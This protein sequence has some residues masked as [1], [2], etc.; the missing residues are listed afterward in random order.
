MSDASR[1][2]YASASSPIPPCV[3]KTR[4]VVK[5]RF[6][7]V[8]NSSIIGTF[9][10]TFMLFICWSNR[11]FV[12]WWTFMVEHPYIEINFVHSVPQVPLADMSRRASFDVIAVLWKKRS[13]VRG[14]KCGSLTT[15]VQT[16]L[17]I[18]ASKSRTWLWRRETKRPFLHDNAWLMEFVLPQAQFWGIFVKG[19]RYRS[20]NAS[21]NSVLFKI[22]P[23]STNGSEVN[24]LETPFSHRL[25]RLR[26][27]SGG[28]WSFI[29]VRWHY[30]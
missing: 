17:S 21:W 6:F 13:P 4:G 19:F 22:K 30:I 3:E 26:C 12:V 14:A 7:H 9:L 27:R 29:L 23:K 20:L 15:S 5:C 18:P 28:S 1:L 10:L 8:Q 25:E 11:K 16:S 2:W 24:Q